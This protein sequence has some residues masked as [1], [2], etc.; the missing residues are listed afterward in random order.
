MSAQL[1]HYN[2]NLEKPKANDVLLKEYDEIPAFEEAFDKISL[3]RFFHEHES[4][5][6]QSDY[7]PQ[8]EIST[9]GDLPA[10]NLDDHDFMFLL[11][12]DPIQ[13]ANKNALF[14]ESHINSNSS[15]KANA[16][17]QTSCPQT[18]RSQLSNPFESSLKASKSSSAT[19]QTK[20]IQIIFNQES[21]A[22]KMTNTVTQLKSSLAETSSRRPQT[23]DLQE[24]N[25]NFNYAP[26]AEQCSPFQ[27]LL[28]SKKIF[29]IERNVRRPTL[30]KLKKQASSSLK[31]QL[32]PPGSIQ[33]ETVLILPLI[34]PNSVLYSTPVELTNRLLA[35]CLKTLDENGNYVNY[36]IPPLKFPAP[37]Q[38]SIKPLTQLFQVLAK[39]K[40]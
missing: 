6:S 1:S 8:K 33:E 38:L 22:L 7:S 27:K 2:H 26:I 15:P 21:P 16:L 23:H 25:L 35:S 40:H 20:N 24:V 5:N 34:V 29:K 36:V 14:P 13:R 4:T 39:R 31:I 10:L 17:L 11:S 37:S 3:L 9:H 32:V 12:Q 28:R 30:S 19:K 18:P